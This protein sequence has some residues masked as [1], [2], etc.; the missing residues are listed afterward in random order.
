M[1][2]VPDGVQP[3]QTA[4]IVPLKGGR[5]TVEV[6]AAVPRVQSPDL[7]GTLKSPLRAFIAKI[8]AAR[9]SAI[10]HVASSKQTLT[11]DER[12]SVA[13]PVTRKTNLETAMPFSWLA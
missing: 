13:F 10:R 12:G 3:V 2:T 1:E 11:P 7:L 9:R 6:N 8:P 5:T 4:F